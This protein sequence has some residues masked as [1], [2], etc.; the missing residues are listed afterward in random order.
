MNF[1]HIIEKTKRDKV[2]DCLGL[3]TELSSHKHTLLGLFL[4]S[5]YR[6]H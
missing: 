5:K 6:F 4:K 2:S 1:I 3:Y